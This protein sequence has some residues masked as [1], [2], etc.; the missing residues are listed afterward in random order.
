MHRTATRAQW[1]DERLALLERE[2]E[3]TRNGD[4]LAAA[5]RDL[6][7][8]EVTE[9]YVF[10][11]PA[12]HRTL[13]ELFDGR[14]QLLVYHFMLPPGA[15]SV[16]ASCS[17]IADGVNG[18]H[19]HLEHHDVMFTAVSRAPLEEIEAYRARMGWSFRWASSYESDFNFDFLVS[20]TEERPLPEYNFRAIAE[21]DRFVGERPGVSAFVLQDGTVFHT[22]SAYGRGVDGI[23]GVYTW[24]DRAPMGRNDEPYWHRRRDELEAAVA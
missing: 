20:S 22:Y 1:R 19:V 11:T 4:A 24:L 17:S 10:D 2:K 15:E 23:W 18:P 6:P 8:V 21:E 16:C 3:H 12:G 14:S 7:W 9:E 13:A 5:R